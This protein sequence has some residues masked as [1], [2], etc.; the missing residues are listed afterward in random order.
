MLSSCLPKNLADFTSSSHE[1]K[2]IPV[3]DF[4]L[5]WYKPSEEKD[6]EEDRRKEGEK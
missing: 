6:D 2:E 3:L 5:E 1:K 4:F